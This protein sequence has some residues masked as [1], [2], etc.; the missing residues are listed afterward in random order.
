MP[1]AFGAQHVEFACDVVERPVLFLGREEVDAQSG[2]Y[3]ASVALFLPVECEG[4]EVVVAEVHHGEEFVHQSVAQPSLCVLTHC[5]VGVPST[6]PVARQ[7]V[8]LAYG[9]A[10]HL[11]P[12]LQCLDTA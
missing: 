2:G 7:V 3:D 1:H 10:T 9:R 4:V 5:G 11:H 12:R 6:A 8:V